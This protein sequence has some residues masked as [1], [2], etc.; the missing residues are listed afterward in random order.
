[1]RDGRVGDVT[2]VSTDEKRLRTVRQ[3]IERGVENLALAEREDFA[4][5]SKLLTKWREDEAELV[6]RI[7]RRT[8]ELEPLPEAMEVIAQFGDL[9]KRLKH[10]DRV[11]LAH[12]VKQTVLSIRASRLHLY[13]G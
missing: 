8:V 13:Y 1:M 3:K 10:A 12:A 2:Q 6:D 5:I 11:K 4:A 9:R 7:D